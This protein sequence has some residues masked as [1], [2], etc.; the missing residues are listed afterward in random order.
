[1]KPSTPDHDSDF[2]QSIFMEGSPDAREALREARAHGRSA[3]WGLLPPGVDPS[4]VRALR[5]FY[6]TDQ[7]AV[8]PIVYDLPGLRFLGLPAHLLSN[9]DPRA[10]P[11]SVHTLWLETD[12]AVTVPA[13]AVF[14]HVRHIVSATFRSATLTFA[15]RSFPSLRQLHLKLDRKARMLAVLPG[16]AELTELRIGPWSTTATTGSMFAAL[17][18]IRRLARLI[19]WRGSLATLDGIEAL[20]SLESVHLIRLARLTDI[21]ALTKLP[22]LREL[23]VIDCV[24]FKSVAA[25]PVLRGVEREV[26]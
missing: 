11:P 21:D 6:A 22:K 14:P 4:D 8:P 15:P 13:A 3:E 19:L 9:L 5:L 26:G 17:E 23:N 1:M 18:P 7:K 10:L 16:L 2:A 24:H 20:H 25:L 12:G